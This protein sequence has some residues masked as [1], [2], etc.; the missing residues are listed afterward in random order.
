MT[1]Y[2]CDYSKYTTK[3]PRIFK[4]AQALKEAGHDVKWVAP[5]KPTK[6]AEGIIAESAKDDILVPAKSK[7]DYLIKAARYL[8]G[9]V[10]PGD[11]VFGYVHIGGLTALLATRGKKGV[12]FYWDYPDPWAGWY[13]V[14]RKDDNL[15]WSIG[16]FLFTWIEKAMYHA[17]DHVFTASNTQLEFLRHQHGKKHNATVVL[18]CPDYS[19]F[20]RN[21]KKISVDKEL[22]KAKGKTLL[23]FVGNLCDQYGI[24]FII[25]AFKR[26]HDYEPKTH[27]A[28]LGNANPPEYLDELKK[29]AHSLGIGDDV[30]FKGPVPH[31]TVPAYLHAAK[32]GFIAYRNTFYNNVGGPNKLFELMMAGVAPVLAD[33]KEFEYYARNNEN[34]MLVKA[35]DAVAMSDATLKLLEHPEMM[36]KFARVNQKKVRELGL[37]WEDQRKKLLA[38]FKHAA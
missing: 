37:T 12:R 25:E 24:S 20:T 4:Y 38:A 15:K 1:I 29:L 19:L 26:V 21:V 35:E 30:T 2:I 5:R 11:A 27:L 23:I 7:L 8:R 16:R 10:Q 34:A 22:P 13:Y 32:I 28:L 36:E 6:E 9:V 18:N 3:Q 14:G 17:A 33:M 31:E